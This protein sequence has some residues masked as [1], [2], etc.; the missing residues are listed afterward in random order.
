MINTPSPFLIMKYGTE[1]GTANVVLYMST[2]TASPGTEPLTEENTI[3]LV[4]VF[5]LVLGSVVVF[6]GSLVLFAASPTMSVGPFFSVSP[7]E[8]VTVVANMAVGASL[9]AVGA[10]IAVPELDTVL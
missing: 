9:M 1:R 5:S 6:A 2:G 7:V 10:A 4:N 3:E 8:P